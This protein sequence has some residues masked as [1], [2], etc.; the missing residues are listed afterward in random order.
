M[1]YIPRIVEV[2]PTMTASQA[3]DPERVD[4]AVF[5]TN[6]E[7]EAGF[8]TCA[9]MNERNADRVVELQGL[10][11]GAAPDPVPDELDAIAALLKRRPAASPLPSLQLAFDP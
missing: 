8:Y 9:G 1:E 4:L 3:A 6:A 7:L 2:G 5:R 11:A 10:I